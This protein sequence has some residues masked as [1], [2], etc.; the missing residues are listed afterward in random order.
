MD[1]ELRPLSR[2]EAAVADADALIVLWR[3]ADDQDASSAEDAL[4]AWV[5]Q[6]VRDGDLAR[7]AGQWLAGHR[8]HGVRARRVVAVRCGDGAARKVRQAVAAAWGALKGAAPRPVLIQLGAADAAALAAAG[9]GIA[10]A[11]YRY[12]TTLTKPQPRALQ[13]VIVGVADAPS[14]HEAFEWAVATVHGQELAKE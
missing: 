6:A 8:V 2:T 10:E 11:S 14:L 7:D 4:G 9:L 5:Q 1:F 12:T 3:D 13:R